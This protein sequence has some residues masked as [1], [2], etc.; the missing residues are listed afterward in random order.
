MITIQIT[1]WDG[2]Y[3]TSRGINR[4]NRYVS[5]SIVDVGAVTA[6]RA[7][8]GGAELVLLGGTMRMCGSS[9]ASTST[10]VTVC[11]RETIRVVTVCGTDR[12]CYCYCA[13]M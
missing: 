10:T 11:G 4:T 12:Y 7:A 8:A 13:M 9:V 1:L 2:K 6:N 5:V 3:R